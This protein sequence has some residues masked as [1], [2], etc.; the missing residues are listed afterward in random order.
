MSTSNESQEQA[1]FEEHKS[2][3]KTPKQL[4]VTVV[5]SFVIP[6]L[7]IILLVNWVTAGD[8]PAAGSAS[9]GAEA[10][11]LR[12]APVAKIEIIDTSAPAQLKNGEQVYTAVCAGC[13]ANGLAGAHKF[14]DKA[15]WAPIIA[16]GLDTMV[17]NAIK[18][19]NAMPAKGG[20]PNL[21]DIEI[22]RAV[23]YMTNAAGANFQEPAAEAAPEKPAAPAAKPAAAPAATTAVAAAPAAAKPA[24]PAA[25]AAAPGVDLAL[26]EK[27]YKQACFA[28]HG[29]GI[30]GAPKLGDKA[31]WAPYVATG[32]DTM[33]AVAIKGKG[34][35]PA[36]GGLASASDADIAAAVHYMVGTV[37]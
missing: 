36:R 34:A 25:A 20:N 13:H 33:I 29:A 11:A 1:H 3:I 37:K 5:L 6:I 30:A 17:T 23:V 2:L 26:G 35:M 32:M 31:A 22:T 18:G 7:V 28:C 4:I 19:K 14:G 15:K 8:R 9:L 21:Q 12:I 16:T 27:L 24:A 10:T